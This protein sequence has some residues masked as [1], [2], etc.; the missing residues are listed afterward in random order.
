MPSP[1]ENLATQSPQL[2]AEPWDEREYQGLIKS[3]QTR[4]NDVQ[5]ETLSTESRFD[6]SYNAAHA[7][8]LA[9]L[10]RQGYRAKNRYIVSRYYPIHWGLVQK[11]GGY[12]PNAKT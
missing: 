11:S 12:S 10:R 3:G 2:V 6:L 5:N 7:L 1:L 4:L 9:A 8:C